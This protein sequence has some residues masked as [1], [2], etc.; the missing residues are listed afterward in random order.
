MKTNNHIYKLSLALIIIIL[1]SSKLFG[2]DKKDSIKALIDNQDYVFEART[3]MP[4]GGRTR[5]L[6]SIYTLTVTKDSVESYLPY[7]GR[8]YFAP[9]D[10]SKGGIEFT[11]KKFDYSAKD[12]KK[13]GWLIIIKPDDARDVQQMTLTV[14]PSGYALL[15]VT[16]TNRQAI[17]FNGIIRKK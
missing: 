17:S 4:M 14:S 11:S 10:P 13:G 7:F 9:I 5:Q 6:T 15:Q 16:S 3:V 8:A 1:C 12:Q 2:Q